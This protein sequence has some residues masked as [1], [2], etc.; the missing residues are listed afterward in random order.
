M[1]KFL[2]I[3]YI[4]LHLTSCSG[5]TPMYKK[6]ILYKEFFQTLA[7]KTDNSKTT[8]N[9]KREMLKMFP[10]NKNIRYIL[11]LNTVSSTSSTVNN[12]DGKVSG[13]EIE[14]L[15][16]AKLY[17]RKNY[18]ELLY[19]FEEKVNAP[20]YLTSDQVLSTLADRNKAEKLNTRNISKKIFNNLIIYLSRNSYNAN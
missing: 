17:E 3:I 7:I 13:Y 16:T 9:I 10:Y 6:N 15:V 1:L 5:Y 8:K 12:I 11:S 19:S 4:M 20:Y 14:T 18:D 2:T